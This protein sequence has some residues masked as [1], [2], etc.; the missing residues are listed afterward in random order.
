VTVDRRGDRVVVEIEDDGPGLPSS[1][2]ATLL[3]PGGVDR[4]DAATGLGLGIP[5]ARGWIEAMGG[6]LTFLDAESGGTV[7][8]VGLRAADPEGP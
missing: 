7:A 1:V 5:I 4:G 6:D 8:V 3:E 2:R